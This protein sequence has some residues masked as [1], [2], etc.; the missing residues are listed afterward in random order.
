MARLIILFI[1]AFLVYSAL[2]G[3]LAKKNLTVKQF[4]AIYFATLLG[5][6][7]LFLGVTGRLH[8][9]FAVLG[10]VLPFLS[11]AIGLVPRERITGRAHTVAFSVD[12]ESYYLPRMGR[13]IHSLDYE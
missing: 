6:A 13:F 9:V 7:L 12:Y 8:P 3:L 4:F 11:R 2:R 5:I 10:A 1:V